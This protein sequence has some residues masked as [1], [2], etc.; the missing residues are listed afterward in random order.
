MHTELIINFPKHA[1]PGVP[2]L[3]LSTPAGQGLKSALSSELQP[4][5]MKVEWSERQR[6]GNL[7]FLEKGQRPSLIPNPRRQ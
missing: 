2:L 5:R 6:E 1:L 4:V 3:I 7:V